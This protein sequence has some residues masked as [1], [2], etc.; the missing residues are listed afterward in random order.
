MRAVIF[1]LETTGLTLPELAPLEKQPRIIEIG[2]LVV[3]GE[4]PVAELS[5][6]VNPGVEIERKIT[7]ITGITNAQLKKA[8]PLSE[9]IQQLHDLFVLGSDAVICHNAPFDTS[10]LRY[11]LRRLEMEKTF[12]WPKRAICTVQEYLPQ[13]GRRP[14][15]IELYER[16]MG[17]PLNQTHRALDDVKALH[18]VLTKDGFYQVFARGD[19]PVHAV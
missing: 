1:D 5:Q 9:A 11:E 13:F 14:R 18:E 16:V 6:L 2:A 19:S 12:P 17:K 10:V 15:L 4:E 3:N 7:Q 8:P